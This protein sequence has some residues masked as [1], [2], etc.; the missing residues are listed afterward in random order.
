MSEV[1]EMDEDSSDIE[2]ADDTTEV[3]ELI[4]NNIDEFNLSD[5]NEAIIGSPGAK[6]LELNSETV[7][8]RESVSPQDFSLLKVLGEGAYGKVFQVR[9]VTGQHQG[10]L[11]A[12][13][14]LKKATIVSNSKVIQHTNAERNILE[15]VK[16]SSL[17]ICF[18]HSRPKE[19]ST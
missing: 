9:K 15:A 17:W 5:L 7:S 4:P 14:V 10:E 2:V 6:S 3:D 11:F 12:M 1:F 16:H 13:K 19:N 18:M 8:G